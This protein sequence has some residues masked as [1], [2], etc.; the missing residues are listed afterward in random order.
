MTQAGIR[1]GFGKAR[2]THERGVYKVVI[3]A[4]A[5]A[6]GRL[7]LELARD[8][9]MAAINDRPFD[10]PAAIARLKALGQQHGLAPSAAC[11]AD[12]AYARGIP[13]IRLNANNLV[14]LG[15]GAALRRI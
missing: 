12:A 8:L 14:Q 2:E 9:V 7:A 5:E 4:P 3:R 13:A 10:V 1:T 15:H 11:I 6:V